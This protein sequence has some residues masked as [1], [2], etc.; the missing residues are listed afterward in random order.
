MSRT[1]KMTSFCQIFHYYL[2]Y[3][4]SRFGFL[5][6]SAVFHSCYTLVIYNHDLVSK[7]QASNQLNG[8][9]FTQLN[10]VFTGTSQNSVVGISTTSHKNNTIDD[11]IDN[12][13]LVKQ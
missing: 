6:P 13:N 8:Y 2:K 9:F 10:L 7:S 11:G 3:R 5:Y 4:I 12:K 1:M